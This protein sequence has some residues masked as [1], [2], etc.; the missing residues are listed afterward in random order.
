MGGRDTER[1]HSMKRVLEKESPVFVCFQ[2]GTSGG[3]WTVL[4]KAS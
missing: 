3:R 4:E 2:M 1:R